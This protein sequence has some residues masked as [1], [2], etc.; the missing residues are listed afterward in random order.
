MGNLWVLLRAITFLFSPMGIAIFHWFMPVS[1]VVLIQSAATLQSQKLTHC[2]H[3]FS[4]GYIQF[5]YW[6]TA[7]F[8]P[9]V[10]AV[11][12]SQQHPSLTLTEHAT[13]EAPAC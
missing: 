13:Q 3:H 8:T 2:G 4:G 7:S 6:P 10:L 1:R 9:V 11:Q 5:G 12:T